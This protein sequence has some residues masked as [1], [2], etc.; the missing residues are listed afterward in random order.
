MRG[1]SLSL[2]LVLALLGLF[3]FVLP[4]QADAVPAVSFVKTG[5]SVTGGFPYTLS[6]K[7]KKPL[8]QDLDIP[9]LIQETGE[10]VTVRIPAGAKEGSAEIATQVVEKTATWNLKA[11]ESADY[12]IQTNKFTL[13]VTPLPQAEFYTS[14]SFGYAGKTST[15]NIKFKNPNNVHR[16]STF[17]LRDQEGN[18]LDERTWNSGEGL[19]GFQVKVTPEIASRRVFSVWMGDYKVNEKDGYGAFTDLSK[20]AVRFVETDQPYVAVTLDCGWYGD[21]M[22]LVLPILE[23]NNAKATFFMTG[24]FLRTFTKEA[25]AARDAGHEIGNHTNLHPKMAAQKKKINR[26][27]QLVTPNKNAKELLGVTPRVFRPPYGD[28]DK[29][30]MALSRAEGMEII[31]WTVDSHDWDRSYDYDKIWKRVTKEI[32]PGYIIL[33]HLNGTH[34]PAILK[35][36]IPYI[37]NDLGLKC[38]TVSELLA[39]GGM[40]LPPLVDSDASDAFADDSPDQDV[41]PAG[42]QEG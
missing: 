29:E 3:L 23:E 35:E 37:Q 25:I 15:I 31:I 13:K 38:V 1:K 32:K 10:T 11:A 40:E 33:F 18:V 16:G 17:Q 6:M 22:P 5:G 4:A 21:Q 8:D 12:S 28:Y 7:A 20:K 9:V 30:V 41:I 42:A 27:S 36:L 14:V 2:V 34:T 19:H 24:F 26:M 39:S